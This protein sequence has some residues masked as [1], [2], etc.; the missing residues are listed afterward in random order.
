[1]GKSGKHLDG[2]KLGVIWIIYL[3][4]KGLGPTFADVT[5]LILKVE[6]TSAKIKNIFR[7]S[8]R[9]EI[10]P[11]YNVSPILVTQEGVN[12]VLNIF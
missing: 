11:I 8:A 12:W 9:F 10:N 2:K 4:L 3:I 7:R 1:M 5:M 6:K